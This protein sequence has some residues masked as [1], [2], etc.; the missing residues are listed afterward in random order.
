MATHSSVLVKKTLWTE[1]PGGLLSTGSHRVRHD[2]SN[3]AAAAAA[4][5]WFLRCL[6]QSAFSSTGY[7]GSLPP[8]Q[9]LLCAG[10]S[11]IATLV[12]KTY[13][14]PNVHSS[15][16][17]TSQGVEAPKFSSTADWIKK[18]HIYIY[19]VVQSPNRVRLFETPGTIGCE[20]SLPLPISQS[21]LKFMS[22]ESVMPYKH[23][24]N[25]TYI[26]IYI[27]THTYTMEY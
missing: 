5:Y 3:L 17:Y 11:E 8:R 6:H 27:Y 9:H 19:I 21:L 7:R 24:Y 12:Q 15:I 4:A 16:I 13:T 23:T 26:Y 18:M 14:H 25:A 1:E 2:W 20:A 22:I 10:F